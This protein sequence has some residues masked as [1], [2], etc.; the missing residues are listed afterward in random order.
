MSRDPRKLKVFALADALVI[1]IYVATKAFP[2]EERFGL[3]S[4]IRRAAVSVVA[5]L[6]EGCARPW[7]RDYLSFVARAVA[8]ASEVRY[9]VDLAVRLD[10]LDRRRGV[11]LI[12]RYG[13]VIQ[14]MQTLMTKVK[15]LSDA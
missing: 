15:A 10:L 9:L 12:D 8:S 2:I 13:G 7:A 1:D 6:V 3:Q 5:N 14:G 11:G 4:Q